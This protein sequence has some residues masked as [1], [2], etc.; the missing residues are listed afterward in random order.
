MAMCLMLGGC[1]SIITYIRSDSS[2]GTDYCEPDSGG[3]I[4]VRR[5]CIINQPSSSPGGV[6]TSTQQPAISQQQKQEGPQ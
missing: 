2:T 3:V 4:S 6:T 1:T 5:D